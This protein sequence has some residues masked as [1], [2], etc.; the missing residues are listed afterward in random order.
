MLVTTTTHYLTEPGAV[1][2]DDPEAIRQAL[3]LHG[4]AWTGKPHPKIG[5]APLSEATYRTVCGYADDVLIEADGSRQ[6]PLKVPA[7]HEPVIPDNADRIVVI[8]GLSAIGRPA[9][10]VCH[11]L[12]MACGLLGI[13]EDTI[14]RPE[15]V[16]Q[17]VQHGYAD[18]LRREHPQAQVLIHP[19]QQ[20]DLLRC[21][22]ASLLRSEVPVAS[23]DLAPLANEPRPD[24]PGCLTMRA[25]GD[26]CFRPDP[27]ACGKVYSNAEGDWILPLYWAP[28]YLMKKEG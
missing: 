13:G 12:P 21:A 8:T 16:E 19:C 28:D 6:L 11:R 5:L 15:H 2:G 20:D 4:L 1:T 23:V 9:K 25:G 24:T 17:A 18:R 26:W 7:A 22:V 10:E 3:A 14:I 27:A